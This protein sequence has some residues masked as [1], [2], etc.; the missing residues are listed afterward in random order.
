MAHETE[1]RDMLIA[2]GIVV[3]VLVLI[4]LAMRNKQTPAQEATWTDP[5]A[6]NAAPPITNLPPSLQLPPFNVGNTP[7]TGGS[8]GGSKTGDHC[9]CS[10]NA[11]GTGGSDYLSRFLQT[12]S[13]GTGIT[14]TDTGLGMNPFSLSPISPITVPVENIYTPPP[15]NTYEQWRHKEGLDMTAKEKQLSSLGIGNRIPAGLSEKQYY[16]M[17]QLLNGGLLSNVSID[18]QNKILA[19]VYDMT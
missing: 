9:G 18:A 2:G 15:A 19:Q 14:T 11:C 3:A 12:M 4:W 5:V 10:S 6:T 13:N 8:S 7:S 16:K 17:W 1:K